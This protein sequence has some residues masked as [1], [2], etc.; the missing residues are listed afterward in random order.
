MVETLLY[1]PVQCQEILNLGRSKIYE[2][3]ATG[4][5]RSCKIGRAIRIPASALREYVEKQEAATAGQQGGN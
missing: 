2:L 5:L 4:A 1:K 3:L